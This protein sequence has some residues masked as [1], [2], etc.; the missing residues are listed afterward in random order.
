MKHLPLALSLMVALTGTALA[1]PDPGQSPRSEQANPSQGPGKGRGPDL[2]KRADI[3]GDGQ[4]TRAEFLTASQRMAEQLFQRLD[5]NGD[6]V[7]SEQERAQAHHKA[8]EHHQGRE[9]KRPV[10]PKA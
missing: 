9:G 1:A 3:N 6:G 8:R 2:F 4:V 7:I 5:T 10:P